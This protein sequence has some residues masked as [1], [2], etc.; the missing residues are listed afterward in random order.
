MVVCVYSSISNSSSETS[1]SSLLSQM[2][3]PAFFDQ[4]DA[5]VAEVWF[6]QRGDVAR[7]RFSCVHDL[8]I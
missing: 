1:I 8:G 2:R 3:A 5:A 4:F 6:I 7:L